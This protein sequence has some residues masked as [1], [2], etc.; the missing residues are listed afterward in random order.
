MTSRGL[1]I[2]RFQ[3]FHNGHLWAIKEILKREDEIIIGIGSAQDSYSLENP[4]TAGERIEIIREVLKSIG[5]LD[6][7]II[8]PIPDINENLAW[9]GRVI[10]LTPRFDRVYSGNELVLMLFEKFGIK[11]I[12]LKH[13]DRDK[14]QGRIIR[15]RILRGEPWE[16]L[17]P[18]SIIPLLKKFSFEERIRRLVGKR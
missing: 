12:R 6:R 18:S 8:V 1:F 17:V 2:G 16:H 7:G 14:Y 3:P 5:A 10:E 13:I 15:E 9:P 4:L 11:T